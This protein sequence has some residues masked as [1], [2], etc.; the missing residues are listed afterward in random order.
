LTSRAITAE[1][2]AAQLTRIAQSATGMRMTIILKLC[3]CFAA[4]VLAVAFYG[5]TR[6]QD[7]ELAILGLVCRAAEGVFVRP[8]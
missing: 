6:E 5:I 4:L 1:G 7:H 2:T 8:R 3:E